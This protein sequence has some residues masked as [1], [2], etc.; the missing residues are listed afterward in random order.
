MQLTNK[1][2]L[3]GGLG[4]KFKTSQYY[5]IKYLATIALREKLGV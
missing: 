3:N 2:T 5:E 4:K 1:R